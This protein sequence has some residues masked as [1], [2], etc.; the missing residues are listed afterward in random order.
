MEG[1]MEAELVLE[2]LTAFEVDGPHDTVWL[3]TTAVVQA[4]GAVEGLKEVVTLL[5][6]DAVKAPPAVDE[7]AALDGLEV[8][9]KVTPELTEGM[10]ETDENEA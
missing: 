9:E 7:A 5:V 3:L 4:P 10:T 6:M 8:A 2:A 1:Y